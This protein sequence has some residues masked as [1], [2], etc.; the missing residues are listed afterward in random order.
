MPTLLQGLNDLADEKA[1][2]GVFNR[3]LRQLRRGSKGPVL[4]NQEGL[5]LDLIRTILTQCKVIIDD[6]NWNLI[7]SAI[8]TRI[9]TAKAQKESNPHTS[10]G[11]AIVVIDDDDDCTNPEA[12]VPQNGVESDQLSVLEKKNKQIVVLKQRLK[13]SRQRAQR[14]EKR[15]VKYVAE[16]QNQK[17][18]KTSSLMIQPKKINACQLVHPQ[19]VH[20]DCNPKKP[21]KH[22]HRGSR[23]KRAFRR[24][25]AH[26]HPC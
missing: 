4:G 23:S 17:K 14:A 5:N 18:N 8:F 2:M 11:N 25:Q 16:R 13:K 26:S 12:I 1:S 6:S 21:L 22:Q 24:E 7:K 3:F 9:G 19:C 10:C 15:L 20:G